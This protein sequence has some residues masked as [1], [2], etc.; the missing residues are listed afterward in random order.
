[1]AKKEGDTV[2]NLKKKIL[3]SLSNVIHSKLEDFA[4]N[5]KKKIE[6]MKKVIIERIF[7]SILMIMAF[8]FLVLA[9]TYYLIEYQGF[10]KTIAFLI[11]AGALLFVSFIIRYQSKK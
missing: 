7:S 1:M 10:T 6:H 5:I 3:E 4:A 11:T 9:F 8:I 2:S